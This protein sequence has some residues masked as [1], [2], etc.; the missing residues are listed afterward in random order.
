MTTTEA[1]DWGVYDI[2]EH[3]GDDVQIVPEED[4]VEHT[5]DEDCVC[6]PT[7]QPV[8][9]PDGSIGWMYGHWAIDGRP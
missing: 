8:E 5:I 2:G 1:K 7:A 3:S 9:R 6:G 4:I